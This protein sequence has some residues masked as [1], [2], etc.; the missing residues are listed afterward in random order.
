MFF[1]IDMSLGSHVIADAA[2]RMPRVQSPH[3]DP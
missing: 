1:P 2:Y 3:E